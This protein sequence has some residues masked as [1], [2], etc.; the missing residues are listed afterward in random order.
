LNISY[1]LAAPLLLALAMAA[2]NGGGS[3][4]VPSAGN[5][6]ADSG[7]NI[8]LW[9]ATHSAVRA[10]PG[11]RVGGLMQC[12]ALIESSG[13]SHTVP[14][15]GPPDFQKRYNLPSSTKGT[16]QIVAVVDA[17]DNPDVA[18]DMAAY[19]T[20]YGLPVGNFTKYNQEGKTSGYPKGNQGWGTE[21]DL[22]VQMV[23][24]TCPNCTIYLIEAKTNSSKNL[25]IAEREA[26]KL[27]AHVVTNSW[28]GGGG[29]PSKSSFDTPGVAY[30]ASA[31][32]GGYGTQDPA[33]FPTVISVGGTLL[34][35]GSGSVYSERVWPDSGGGCSVES[36]PA[37]QTDPTCTS[38]TENDVSAVADG[39]AE[40]DTYGYSG[41]ITI[42][43]TSVSSPLIA[44]VFGLA[45][46][47]SKMKTD[48]GERFWT[49]KGKKQSD[50][51]YISEGQVMGCP[52]QYA[53]T[54]LCVAGTGQFGNYSGPAGWGTPNGIGAF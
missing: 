43:G 38:R 36:K 54:Y 22:D 52:S 53:G 20:E 12:D 47:A 28:G 6:S 10:C 35:K 24:A 46:N 33:D 13:I 4:S 37:W 49:L 26:V 41:W 5:T 27:G 30:M 9:Q 45:G 18:S 1:K 44:G 48:G 25:Y 8:P 11:S 23:S 40:Y 21:I 3:P 16:G 34:S 32:D 19:R 29:N 7:R 50:L 31:G 42:G 14:G 17:F 51:N 2:C 15:W 39:V